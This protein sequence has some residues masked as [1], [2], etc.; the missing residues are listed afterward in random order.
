MFGR[1]RAAPTDPPATTNV[2]PVTQDTCEDFQ[3]VDRK[4]SYDNA[5][6]LSQSQL[7]R[8]T[9]VAAKPT[10]IDVAIQVPQ[11][12]L[13]ASISPSSLKRIKKDDLFH[14]AEEHDRLYQDLLLAREQAAAADEIPRDIPQDI[15]FM[16]P[17][18]L[19]ETRNKDG[20]Y[21]KV[22][23]EQFQAARLQ[24]ANSEVL[25]LNP[26]DVDLDDGGSM[27]RLLLQSPPATPREQ[28]SPLEMVHDDDLQADAAG[29]QAPLATH[30]VDVAEAAGGEN[31]A[32]G[33]VATAMAD[34]HPMLT[35]QGMFDSA[36][37]ADHPIA[38]EH[39]HVGKRYEETTQ[40]D[41]LV[42]N[43]PQMSN[44][45]NATINVAAA[46][47]LV[48]IAEGEALFPTV[49]KSAKFEQCAAEKDKVGGQSPAIPVAK[50]PPMNAA[51]APIEN[52]AVNVPPVA[53]VEQ[54]NDVENAF[55]HD[56][57]TEISSAP[58][59][60]QLTAPEQSFRGAARQREGRGAGHRLAPIE[61]FG[62]EVADGVVM[63]R[64]NGCDCLKITRICL[65]VLAVLSV[66]ASL[67]YIISREAKHG[68]IS[69]DDS[70]LLMHSR[71]PESVPFGVKDVEE[72][73]EMTVTFSVFEPSVDDNSSVLVTS[74]VEGASSADDTTTS[75]ES[76]F[77]ALDVNTDSNLLKDENFELS[78]FALDAAYVEDVPEVCDA[79][80]RFDDELTF[81][82]FDEHAALTD[83]NQGVFLDSPTSVAYEHDVIISSL[84]PVVAPIIMEAIQVAPS[85]SPV[86]SPVTTEAIQVASS[87][88]SMLEGIYFSRSGAVSLLEGRTSMAQSSHAYGAFSVIAAIL[89]YKAY[90]AC[91]G[92]NV[93]VAS[94]CRGDLN[95]LMVRWQSTLQRQGRRGRGGNGKPLPFDT[96]NYEMLTKEDLEKVLLE[97]F[98]YKA[99]SHM[100]K[101]E[102]VYKTCEKYSATLKSM[103]SSSIRRLL[104]IRGIYAPE[105]LK[106]DKLVLLA[107]ETG[108]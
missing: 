9:I 10:E 98:N 23:H 63:Q 69:S 37:A 21:A 65:A 51:P 50:Y 27:E 77:D 101:F 68:S 15:E 54:L 16:A 59:V 53:A 73:S 49:T 42:A 40:F 33:N 43:N 93:G 106:R 1:R 67:M 44:M 91:R 55:T 92:G 88:P 17:A 46:D 80:I 39:G 13:A 12:I 11:D 48:A 76:F 45:E 47:P 108:I 19:D 82:T 71:E 99:L 95:T 52:P 74:I 28:V 3:I 94:V 89:V 24:D 62:Q 97:G 87:S 81:S 56:P 78:P 57:V 34:N 31:A 25:S 5:P 14:A 66:P 103:D 8:Q 107:V 104:Q 61:E 70:T 6:D 86:V 58:V 4:L 90:Q 38:S 2:K 29:E 85:L 22:D 26:S 7:E 83:S 35:K 32:A 72:E 96:R 102:L 105:N 79:G 84:S 60:E 30:G 75:E 20:L 64:N 100:S 18:P 41:D 36:V